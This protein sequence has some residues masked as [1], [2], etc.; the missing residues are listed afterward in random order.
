[1]SCEDELGLERLARDPARFS[2]EFVELAPGDELRVDPALWQDAIV[3]V[4]HGE[5]ELECIS[6]E[7]RRFAPTSIVCFSPVMRLLRNRGDEPV[8]LV[9]ISRRTSAP[10]HTG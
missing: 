2:K 8:R 4:E 1:M 3:F 5:I 10:R 7:C 9:A 6:G